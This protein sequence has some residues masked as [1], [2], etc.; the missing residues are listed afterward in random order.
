MYK[1]NEMNIIYRSE[2]QQFHLFN[3]EISYIFKISEDG[4]LLHL[5]YG[6]NLPDNDYSHLIE[7]HHRPMTT[8]RNENDLLYSLEHLKQ[9]FP[10]YG[11]TDFRH[12]AISLL[13]KNGSRLSDFVYQGYE[14]E[15]GKPK[16]EGLPATYVDNN[17]ESKTLKVYILD[18]VTNV[19]VELLYT[20]YRDY[21]VITR[22]ARVMNKGKDIQIIE[23]I[24]SLSLD[25]PDANYEWQQLS[26]AW[27]RER[28]IKSRTLQQG[29]QSIESTRGISSHQHNPFVT[30]KR[31]NTDENQGEA[32]GAAL[33]Y[34]GNFLI[35]AEVDTWDVTRLQVGINPF[36]FN[37]KLNPGEIF[38]A[39][40]AILVYS[41]KGLNAMSQTFHQLFRKRLARGKWREKDR[42]VLINN[43]EATYFDFDEE[44]LVNIA[45]KAFDVG[46]ELFVLDDGWFGERENDCAGLGDWHVNPKRL[47]RGIG[48]LSEKI[49][50]FGMKFGLWFEP[51]MVNK[52]SELYRTHPNWII[53]TPNR[54]PNH[55][56][57]QYVLNFGLDEVVENIFDQM[58]KIIDESNLDYIK[59]DMNRPLTDV[60]DS[61]L[62]ADQQGEV[63]HRYVLGVYRLYEKL[64]TKYP[65]ILFES[66]SS[67]GGRFDPGMLHYAPQAWASDD[68]DAI[69]RLKIQYGTSMLYPLSSI[70]AHVS[71]VPNHQTNRITPI[72]TRGN[73]AFFGAFGYELDLNELSEGDL[74]IVKEQIA[75][76]KKYRTIIHNGTFYRLLSPF[77]DDNQTA[78]MVV[79][80]DKK[81]AIVAHYK[82]LNE[83]NAPYRRLKLKGLDNDGLY[84]V[85][86]NSLRSGMELMRAGLV[87]SDASS[88]QINDQN[89]RP[90]TFDFDSKIWVITQEEK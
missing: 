81:T 19:Q 23:N 54:K 90:E 26:G 76:Y 78:W 72:K 9:E 24:S 3:Q 5:Y 7:M 51:E 42:P 88:G 20:I 48:S 16:L 84:N 87:C 28:T 52:D 33:V 45:K 85:G 34:S 63:F 66:C 14:V 89:R 86:Q 2:N 15:E 13:Q 77:D 80:H 35:Q 83:V 25:L 1:D 79:S 30:L 44:K 36:G 17:D 60:F 50:S 43:W 38:T 6:E 49:R 4:K 68:S 75:F 22:S 41:S 46:I 57:N 37:W 18:S 61:H 29:I 40:E 31:K 32:I 62:L 47:P 74:R 12:P 64:I 69:E 71:I 56:R 73:V 10:E 65:N 39:P 55:G 59:W 58:C 53:S 27:G 11:T 67:G 82:T 8:Y 21:P 70:G